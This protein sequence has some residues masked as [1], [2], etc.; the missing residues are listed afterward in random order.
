VSLVT[1]AERAG[2]R[3][4]TAFDFASLDRLQSLPSQGQGW[5][6]GGLAVKTFD[7]THWV[8]TIW[9]PNTND[10]H[11]MPPVWPNSPPLPAPGVAR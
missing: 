5:E 7:R 11:A 2:P 9:F 3:D 10:Q 4:T 8:Y 1:V 6:D